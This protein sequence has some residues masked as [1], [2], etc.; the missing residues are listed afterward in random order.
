MRGAASQPGGIFQSLEKWRV[1]FPIVGKIRGRFSNHW[2]TAIYGGA[3]ALVLGASCVMREAGISA[4]DV[5]VITVVCP[6]ISGEPQRLELPVDAAGMVTAP[7][8]GEMK[9][10]GMT[11][12]DVA[13]E[14]R[15]LAAEN[16]ILRE[17]QISVSIRR[18]ATD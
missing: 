15:R 18:A 9:V 8:L 11:R 7:V 1:I 12:G 6:E 14:I 2:K 13:A 16:N 5:V 10:A 17:P 3:A 4:G